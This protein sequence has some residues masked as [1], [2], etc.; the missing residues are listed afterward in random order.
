[1]DERQKAV[2]DLVDRM[3][4]ATGLDA[5]GLCRKADL[6]PST[7]TRFLKGKVKHTL[8]A[9]T[10][11]KLSDASGVPIT[12]DGRPHDPRLTRITSSYEAMS[13]AAKQ[14]LDDIALQFAASGQADPPASRSPKERA[15]PPPLQGGRFQEN[16]ASGRATPHNN[17]ASRRA[18]DR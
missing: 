2:R 18:S 8:S 4:A 9:K 6:S 15:P 12:M 11:Q 16:R 10:L 7:L 5:T 14:L 1:M 13:E 17:G 3:L